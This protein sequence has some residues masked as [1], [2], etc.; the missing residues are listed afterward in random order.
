[1][2][3]SRLALAALAASTACG[4]GDGG[5]TITPPPARTVATVEVTPSSLS[6]TVPGSG[7]LSAIA[8][9]AS[10]AIMSST[11]TWT[12]SAASVASV[13]S[14]GMVTAVANGTATITA[15]AEGKSGSA[16]ITVTASQDGPIV[17][18]ADVGPAGGT[19][20][21]TEVGVTIPAGQLA[22]TVTIVIVKDTVRAPP[23]PDAAATASYLID[24]LPPDRMV[25][26]RVRLKTTAALSGGL[27]IGVT[28]PTW[29]SGDQDNV[30]LGTTIVP[31]TDSAG[32]LVGTVRL[33][34]RVAGAPMS[35]LPV[36]P[37][38]YG[39]FIPPRASASMDPQDLKAAAE[40]SGLMKL[41]NKLSA[42]GNFDVW[43]IGP[44]PDM[45]RKVDRV[46]ALSEQA[47][48]QV[49]AM[50]Y[51]IAFR[52]EWPVSAYVLPA[53]WNGAYYSVLPFPVDPNLGYMA[54]NSTRVDNGWFPGTVI[55]EFFHFVQGGFLVGKDWPS[56][57]PTKW[58]AEATSTWIAE[59][60]PGV[61]LP[62]NHPTV[63]SWRDSLWSGLPDGMVAN[64]GYGKAPIVKWMANTYGEAKV[65]Q[66]YADVQTGANP[67]SAFL[68]ALPADREAWWVD[69]LKTQL[70]G[71][72]YPFWPDN[73]LY[74][75]G[76]YDLTLQAGRLAYATDPLRPF[77]VEGDFLVRDTAR[78]GPAFVLPVSLDT[79]AMPFATIAA[80]RRPAA[81]RAFTLI[82]SGDTVRIPGSVLRTT[83]KVLLLFTS[84]DAVAPYTSSKTF[85]IRTDLSIPEADWHFPSITGLND[86][87]QFV[88]DR[89]GDSVTLDV[90]ENATQVWSFI[91]G[92]GTWK[93][94]Q[95][96][97]SASPYA[98]YTWAVDPALADTLAK[99]GITMQST[100]TVGKGDSV[101]VTGRFTWGVAGGAPRPAGLLPGSPGDG[102]MI[103]LYVAVTVVFST[104]LLRR[105]RTRK[106]LP[107]A[108]AGSL[109]VLSACIGL[110][111]ISI[112]ESFEY[113]FTKQ[114][115]LQDPANPDAPLMELLTGS[116]KTTMNSY[117]L[118]HWVYF[119]NTEGQPDSAK[120]TCTGSGS[121]TYTVSGVGY[122]D[123]VRPP[124]DDDV[125]DSRIE[126]LGRA[127]GVDL[128][129]MAPAIRARVRR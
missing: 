89:E 104:L 128:G 117:R 56:V 94:T 78:F 57:S 88:C 73:A 106:Y 61:A 68:L 32:Y 33:R 87:I 26:M 126:A 3:T 60:H 13:S 25:Q 85:G 91:S 36:S 18:R 123:G 109:A 96:N 74:P 90:A 111:S 124:S 92:A 39:R 30:I 34:G 67:I 23:F 116:G 27:G 9:D 48:D 37:F 47:R 103:P 15:T 43:G 16:S 127:I 101:R 119:T 29:E 102:G 118:E 54:F 125:S 21:A 99:M 38:G 98:T 1:M 93:R 52:T 20:G 12:S 75:P 77:G 40:L 107:W 24:G 69:F 121:A 35:L 58:L 11:I 8:K 45:A 50:G 17:A 100:M 28:R 10:G 105:G 51:S 95:Q 62:Y 55:H 14:S 114:R 82:G 64:S 4:G 79:A 41:T 113:T 44:D 71:T 22:A 122:R 2:R 70:A 19:V 115:W 5:S 86:G 80:F 66:V 72:I 49:L 42:N 97:A 7:Q 83:D 76:S 46:A 65:K 63:L 31:A 6:L 81:G 53:T 108:V 112:D 110:I 120:G 129:R 59:K 84:L